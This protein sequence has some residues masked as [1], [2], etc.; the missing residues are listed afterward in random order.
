MYTRNNNA[1]R[2]LVRNTVQ[3]MSVDSVNTT[4]LAVGDESLSM[5]IINAVADAKDVDPADLGTPLYEVVDPDAI[6]RLFQDRADGIPRPSGQIVF[7]MA[8]C[9]VTVHDHDRVTVTPRNAEN[10]DESNSVA[11]E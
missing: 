1:F 4:E 10:S 9:K 8:D 5:T 2:R 6:D 7:T 3:R 11:G